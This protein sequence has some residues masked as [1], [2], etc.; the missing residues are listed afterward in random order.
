MI[1]HIHNNFMAATQ[2]HV[3]G[4]RVLVIEPSREWVEGKAAL[5]AFVWVEA[6]LG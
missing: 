3:A 5:Q 6:T 2:P 4:R 1:M